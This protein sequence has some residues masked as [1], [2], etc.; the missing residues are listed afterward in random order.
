MMPHE[1]RNPGR[2]CALRVPTNAMSTTRKGMQIARIPHNASK[3]GSTS[4]EAFRCTACVKFQTCATLSKGIAVTTSLQKA[5]TLREC[6]GA[7]TRTDPPKV[8]EGRRKTKPEV[9]VSGAPCNL[10]GSGVTD[11]G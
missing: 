5:S 6:A 2:R 9:V 10:D 7:N 4:T 8:V 11:L 3:H 1:T